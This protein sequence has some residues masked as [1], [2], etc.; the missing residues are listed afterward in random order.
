MNPSDQNSIRRHMTALVEYIKAMRIALQEINN[1]SYNN[2][3]LRVGKYQG[4]S[5]FMEIYV[6]E[7][8]KNAINAG[9]MKKTVLSQSNHE[10][11]VNTLNLCLVECSS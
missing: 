9:I 1:H 10:T 11:S 5:F 6:N 4:F 2:F 3:L 8:V 7:V